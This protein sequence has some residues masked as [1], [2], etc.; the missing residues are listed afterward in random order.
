VCEVDFTTFHKPRSILLP[1]Y[2]SYLDFPLAIHSSDP[3]RCLVLYDR[4]EFPPFFVQTVCCDGGFICSRDEEVSKLARQVAEKWWPLLDAWWDP[5]TA[6]LPASERLQPAG[7]VEDVGKLWAY[8]MSC[9]PAIEWPAGWDFAPKEVSEGVRTCAGIADA[10]VHYNQADQQ[11]QAVCGD[12][13]A[14]Q[15]FTGADGCTYCVHAL[16]LATH[17]GE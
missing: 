10:W 1:E 16:A 11:L 9:N 17:P 14:Y 4:E 13:R 7:V 2:R 3:T 12:Y 6:H 15:A 8:T 5:L